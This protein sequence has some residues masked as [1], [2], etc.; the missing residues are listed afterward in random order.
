MF[1]DLT[2]A[3]SRK[4]GVV[5]VDSYKCIRQWTVIRVPD[6]VQADI[7]TMPHALEN[8]AQRGYRCLRYIGDTGREANWRYKVHEFDGIQF[9]CDYFARCQH[10]ANFR[11]ESVRILKPLRKRFVDWQMPFDGFSDL[12]FIAALRQNV[13]RDQYQGQ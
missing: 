8:A 13:R 2:S 11:P 10:V 7:L 9:V 12:Q 1:S 3:F 5:S 6:K 4:A